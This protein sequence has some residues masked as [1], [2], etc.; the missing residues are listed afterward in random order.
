VLGAGNTDFVVPSNVGK[1]K[2][3]PKSPPSDMSQLSDHYKMNYEHHIFLSYARGD[4]WTPWVKDRFLPR[5]IAY[6]E[7]EVGELDVS[8]DHQIRAGAYWDENL[9]GRLARSRI[10]VALISANYFHSAYCRLEMALMLEREKRLGLEGHDEN[11]GLLIPVRLGDGLTFPDVITR[12]QYHDFVD[13]ADPD[14][15]NGSTRASNFNDSIKK[16][17]QIIRDTLPRV[18]EECSEDW[19]T[20]TGGDFLEALRAK[21]LS[22]PQPPRLIV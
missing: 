16:L 20:F 5:L 1:D 10:M 18:P 7:S 6:L 22:V 3:P 21:K 8:V 17:V 11:Y 13:F 2:L 4:L 19:L 15:P 12:V 9:R 14:L